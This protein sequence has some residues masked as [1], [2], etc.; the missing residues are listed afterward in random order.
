MLFNIYMSKLP[1]PPKDLN[2]TSYADDLTLT[3]DPQVERLGDMI[4]PYLNTLHDWQESRKLKLSAE[5]SSATVFTTW[6]KEDKF[7]PHLTINNSPIPF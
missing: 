4:T 7:D 3:T 1:L 5:K 6:S 2:I